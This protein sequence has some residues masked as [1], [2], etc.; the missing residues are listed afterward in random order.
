MYDYTYRGR[1]TYIH[2]PS[3]Y[4]VW[5]KSVATAMVTDYRFGPVRRNV[6]RR[7]LPRYLEWV[8]RLGNYDGRYRDM[9]YILARGTVAASLA[10]PSTAVN[11]PAEYLEGFEPMRVSGRWTLYRKSAPRP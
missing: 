10:S 3:Y 4:I 2:F 5:E 1:P 9:D 6:D 7:L 11:I 8:A